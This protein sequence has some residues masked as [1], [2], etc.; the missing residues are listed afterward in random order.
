MLSLDNSFLRKLPG[1]LVIWSM[2]ATGLCWNTIV[3]PVPM[4]YRCNKLLM[5][6]I[7]LLSSGNGQGVERWSETYRI[8]L[9]AANHRSEM[10]LR[11]TLEWDSYWNFVCKRRGNFWKLLILQIYILFVLNSF[12]M[13]TSHWF[14]C[15]CFA[16]AWVT[17]KSG[18]A[19][20]MNI[21][22]KRWIWFFFLTS[23]GQKIS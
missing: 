7:S 10:M 23:T 21:I 18:L 6:F 12:K 8:Y 13:R 16:F 3:F 4:Y 17:E 14:I 15:S 9:Q 22:I 20:P 5:L 11:H 2:E 1:Q 19:V